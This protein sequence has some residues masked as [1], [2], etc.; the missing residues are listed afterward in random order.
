MGSTRLKGTGVY[1][2]KR[3]TNSVDVHE[4]VHNGRSNLEKTKATI[5]H[6]QVELVWKVQ[7][8]QK[9]LCSNMQQDKHVG[10]HVNSFVETI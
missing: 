8:Y 1:G 2:V 7:L 3:K 6:T 9:L 5:I 10:A 4:N